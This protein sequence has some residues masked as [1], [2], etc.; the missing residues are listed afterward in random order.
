MWGREGLGRNEGALAVVLVRGR[1]TVLAMR[2]VLTKAQ[3]MIS[4]DPLTCW[5]KHWGNMDSC[6]IFLLGTWLFGSN[7]V[8]CAV[9]AQ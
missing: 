4:T 1:D 6:S 7:L 2:A 5:E 9:I 3:V 8:A